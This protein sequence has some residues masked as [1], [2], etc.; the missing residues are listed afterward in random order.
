MS[1]STHKTPAFALA[2][3]GLLVRRPGLVLLAILALI[4]V[5]LWGTRS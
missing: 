5:S 2:Y 4:G 3:A 1:D